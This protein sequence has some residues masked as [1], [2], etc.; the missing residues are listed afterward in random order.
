MMKKPPGGSP[1]V[2][3]ISMRV[4]TLVIP[5][6]PLQ[7]HSEYSLADRLAILASWSK[8]PYLVMHDNLCSLS[9]SRRVLNCSTSRAHWYWF[10]L[11]SLWRCKCQ[12]CI[13][14]IQT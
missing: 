7:G 13:A 6:P 4:Q 11:S 10:S 12:E 9:T 14:K 3:D 1:G 2:M 5:K 8:N